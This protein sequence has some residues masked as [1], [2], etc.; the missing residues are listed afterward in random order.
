MWALD[1]EKIQLGDAFAPAAIGSREFAYMMIDE[2]AGLLSLWTDGDVSDAFAVAASALRAALWLWLEDDDRS[3]VLARTV[4]EQTARLR[5]WRLKPERAAKVA[6]R[7]DRVRSRDWLE[8]AGWR[9]LSVLNRSLGEFA[10]ASPQRAKWSGAREALIKIQPDL[11]SPSPAAQTARGSTLNAVAFAF[12]TEVMNA[13][14]AMHP[15]IA[16]ALATVLPYER[17]ETSNEIEGWLE[18]C[19]QHRRHSFGEPEFAKPE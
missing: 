1:Q 14:R 10:H 17:S 4:L 7:G 9:R 5:T 13:T 19:W 2:A 11:I 18:R 3:L 8:E 12:G 6:A 16:D 15:D